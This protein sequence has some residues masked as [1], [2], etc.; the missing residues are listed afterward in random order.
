MALRPLILYVM[1]TLIFL[2]VIVIVVKVSYTVKSYVPLTE[3]S[4]I[5]G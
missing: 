5:T 4:L 1:Y 2:T 3:R